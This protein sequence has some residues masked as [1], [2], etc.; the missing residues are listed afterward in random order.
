MTTLN[1]RA[2]KTIEELRLICHSN[3]RV[4]VSII[5]EFQ[6]ISNLHINESE[7]NYAQNRIQFSDAI[8]NFKREI[9][10]YNRYIIVDEYLKV[11]KAEL[12]RLNKVNSNPLTIEYHIFPRKK[13]WKIYEDLYLSYIQYLNKKE[14]INSISEKA[15][16][17]MKGV[18]SKYA[19]RQRLI[20]LNNHFKDPFR[21]LFENTSHYSSH[22]PIAQLIKCFNE[23][24]ETTFY[25]IRDYNS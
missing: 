18:R 10:D 4:T 17:L 6:K 11:L 14:N 2:D 8:L 24:S 1:I 9:W 3:V 25:E 12:I 22:Q 15:T 7:P 19:I 16:P 21:S 13:E 20:Y 5:S 23:V